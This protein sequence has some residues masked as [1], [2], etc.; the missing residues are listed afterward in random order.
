MSANSKPKANSTN[1]KHG[2]IVDGILLVTGS[3]TSILL[4]PI[5]QSLD[6]VALP[7]QTPIESSSSLLVTS[8]WDNRSSAT[9][10]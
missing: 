4:E 3:Y 1:H 6:S 10:T 5:D 2:K 8:F 7:I 9:S